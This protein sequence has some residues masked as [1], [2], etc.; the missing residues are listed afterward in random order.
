V[1]GTLTVDTSVLRGNSARFGGGIQNGL[2]GGQA[3][4]IV[5]D[6]R[7]TGNI[8]S[9]GGGIFN[10]NTASVANSTV[11]NN[12]ASN[13]G[14]GIAN[15]GALTATDCTLSGNSA[16]FGGGISNSSMAMVTGCTLAGNAASTSGGGIFTPV[17]LGLTAL[18]NIVAGNTGPIGPDLVGGI[19]TNQGHN[20]IGNTLG[21]SG[22]VAS[23]LLNVNPL[24][25]PLGDFG[26]PTPTMALLRGS[27]AIDAGDNAN[28]PATD[29]RGFARIVNGTIDIGAFES[30]GLANQ[31][32]TWT[33]PAAIL[34]STALS[35]TQLN[36]T[37]EGVTGG[38]PPGALTYTPDVGTILTAG[39]HTLRVTAAKTDDYNAASKEV[40]I[41]VFDAA[42]ISG[43]AFKDIN[44]DGEV[45]YGEEGAVGV[46]VSLRGAD[47]NGQPVNESTTSLASGYYCFDNLLPGNYTV[48]FV[49]GGTLTSGSPNHYDVGF[50]AIGTGGAT[51]S[52][53]NFALAPASGD[54]LKRG[55]TA[56]IGFWQNKNGQAL[57]KKM[58]GAESST[59]LGHWLAD[60]FHHMF[61]NV[62][63]MTDAQI[64]ALYQQA[65]ANKG[66]KTEAQFFATALSMYVTSSVLSGGAYAASY[67]F[68]VTADGARVATFN[69]GSNGAVVGVANNTT[70]SIMDIMLALDAQ[71]TDSIIGTGTLFKTNQSL[72]SMATSLLSSINDAG[73][74]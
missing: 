34:S 60:N 23:D 18:N 27:P 56:G 48:T 14:G 16:V 10:W 8:A 50:P 68:T 67:G 22:F 13:D 49:S 45:D 17:G 62:D 41:Q 7:L 28:A 6:S 42:R 44:G 19:T 26:G 38:P 72:R 74:I 53:N 33:D 25:T 59:A 57:I 36:A 37:V 65:F 71:A 47:M 30:P 4:L 20:L 3:T 15:E 66:E 43:I 24:L 73:G 1:L 64:A 31:T 2:Y 40:T 39:S 55:Q 69:V 70:L 58:N 12:S 9:S 32:I 63:G 35:S 11:D 61:Q 5:S 21:G 52:T 29:Q 54:Q 51:S 46:V